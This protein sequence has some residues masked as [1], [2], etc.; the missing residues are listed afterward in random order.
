LV[1]TG[2]S[3]FGT[4]NIT[5]MIVGSGGVWDASEVGTWEIT[6]W[7]NANDG[8]EYFATVSII[9][10][11]GK[12]VS[13]N[14]DGS[15]STAIA[16]DEYKL[17]V[18]GTDSD[19]NIFPQSV[20]W[21]ENGLPVPPS[22]IEG[23]N[24]LYNWSASLA[25]DHT[26]TYRSPNGVVGTWDVN[27]SAHYKVGTI[28]L[29]IL[30][31]STLQLETFEVR[32]QTFDGW[33]NQI[34]VP[35]E[36]KLTLSGRMTAEETANGNWTITTLDEGKQTVTLSVHQES[37]SGEISVDGTIA[38]FFE[39][40]GTM[41]YVAAGFAGLIFIVLLVVIL[42]VFRSGDS[43]YDDDDEDDDD[44][45]YDEG[46]ADP[47]VSNPVGPTGPGPGGPPPSVV[48]EPE[49]DTSW[50]VDHRV[51]DEGTEWAEDENGTWWYRD[52]G[53]SEWNEWTD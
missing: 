47:F 13:L 4:Q 19:G 45:E 1:N 50:Q 46:K 33:G 39:A 15:A 18:N 16:G 23:V 49:E 26:L 9:V 37:A 21:S 34:P 41:Y 51:D 11:H 44:Y 12:A 29:D 32:V 17:L 24:G 8:A 2:D 53:N 7:A 20:L 38:G 10:T 43:E 6:A 3:G 14:L 5:S 40:G 35:Q 28:T 48:S 31:E 27:V 36:S 25:G 22:T 52:P 30:Q 42:M